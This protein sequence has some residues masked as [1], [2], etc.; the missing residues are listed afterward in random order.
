MRNAVSIT[1]MGSICAAGNTLDLSMASM[2]AGTR[3]CSA[4][5][6]IKSSLD[7]EYPVFE[8]KNFSDELPGSRTVKLAWKALHEALEQAGLSEKELNGKNVGICIG[9]T[10]GCTLN[11]EPFYRDFKAGIKPD[12]KPIHDFL[13]NNPALNI[14][15]ALDLKGPVSCPVNACASGTDAIGIAASW[16][17]DGICDIAIAGGTDELSRITY[18]GFI[19]LLISSTSPC[20]PFDKNRN[21]LN[22]GEGAGILILEN[23]KRG[24]KSLGEICGY[25][26][27]SDAYHPTKPHPEGK[28]LF[29]ALSMAF[30]EAGI[31]P[32]KTAFINAHGTSTPDNDRAE[33]NVIKSFFPGK[34][35]VFSS[36]SYTGHTLGAAGAIEAVFTLRSLFDGRL[37]ATAGFS[38]YDEACGIIPTTENIEINSDYAVSNSL[39]FGGGNSCLIFRKG[40]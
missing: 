7:T 20:R 19:S 38:D 17:R 23:N 8:V 35:P 31:S 14:S 39:A 6:L 32:D 21:G 3:N 40:G 26:T 1:G 36:K 29:K 12:I 30:A 37:P 34:V 33:G 15:K 4:P 18:L 10:V 2:Y 24:R 22:L 5:L 13:S 25:G 9:T 27:C 28:G 11:N 16:I